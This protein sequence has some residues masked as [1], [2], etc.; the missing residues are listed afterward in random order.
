[1]VALLLGNLVRLSG[2][3]GFIDPNLP[4][5]YDGIRTDLVPCFKQDDIIQNQ[6]LR[7][8]V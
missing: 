5:Y 6:F 2:Q 7:I 3:Q 1:M 8:H 4:V